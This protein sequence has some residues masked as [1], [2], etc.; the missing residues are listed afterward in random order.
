MFAARKMPC[1][2]RG[3]GHDKANRN[4]SLFAGVHAGA[5]M[6][7]R[8]FAFFVAIFFAVFILGLATGLEISRIIRAGANGYL[9]PRTRIYG[10]GVSGRRATGLAALRSGRGD[11]AFNRVVRNIGNE[12]HARRG[13]IA[14][15]NGK[16]CSQQKCP[17]FAH[18]VFSF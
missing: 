6:S 9:A 10:F 18:C 17:K 11:N 1:S 7:A 15:D 2:V 4:I 5:G 13:G 3:A 14:A 12:A 16:C 8:R